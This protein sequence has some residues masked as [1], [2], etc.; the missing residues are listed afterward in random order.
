MEFKITSQQ[1]NPF[2]NR[3][4]YQIKIQS[5][6]GPSINEI[7]KQLNKDPELTVIKKILGKFGTS[8]FTAE[9]F[10]Y[11]NKEAKKRIETIPKKIKKKTQEEA[12]KKA[13]EEKTKQEPSTTNNQLSNKETD[14]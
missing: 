5:E 4:E 8:E 14:T 11:E 9:V 10:I 13:E 3:E 2:L 1:K 12:K 6:S 7:Q